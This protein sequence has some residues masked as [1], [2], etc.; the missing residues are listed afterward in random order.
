MSSDAPNWYHMPDPTLFLPFGG[1]FAAQVYPPSVE[2]RMYLWYAAAA[3][4]M[5]SAEMATA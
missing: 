4:F 3:I 5:P 2:I 1:Y